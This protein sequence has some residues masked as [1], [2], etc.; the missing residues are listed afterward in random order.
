MSFKKNLFFGLGLSLLLLFIS[1]LA[2]YISIHNLIESSEMV[3]S[4][5]RVIKNLDNTLSLLKDAETGQRGYLLTGK[6]QFLNPYLE[7]KKNIEVQVDKVSKQIS[8][9]QTQKD[10][11][12]NLKKNINLRLQILDNNLKIK[13]KENYVDAEQLELGKKI[14]G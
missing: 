5:N 1:S 2:S 12:Q 11:F 9:T 6:K 7:A 13:T 8:T 14:Y 3:R 10:N 4:S